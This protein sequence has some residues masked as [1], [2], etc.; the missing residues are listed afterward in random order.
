MQ[1]L[2]AK[3][4]ILS[5]HENI[6]LFFFFFIEKLNNKDLFLLTIKFRIYESRKIF[7]GIDVFLKINWMK[8]IRQGIGKL[9]CTVNI[10]LLMVF[11]TAQ[12]IYYIELV[13]QLIFATDI[14]F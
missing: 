4:S 6:F 12:K 14:A 8:M 1:N 3:I 13:R 9:P 7:E 11:V 2:I 10:Q 5:D